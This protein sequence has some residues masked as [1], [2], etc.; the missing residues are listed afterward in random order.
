SND[1]GNPG[2]YYSCVSTSC[3]VTSEPVAHQIANPVAQFAKDNNG[4]IVELPA[5][6]A[7]TASVSGSLVFGIGTQS[8]KAISGADVFPVNSNPEFRTT[9]HGQSYPGFIDSGSN[10]LFFLNSSTSS[11]PVC[12]DTSS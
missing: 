12:P 6:S 2:L 1:S 4:V 11:L 7:A 8:N 3:Q 10:G 9:F 5:V